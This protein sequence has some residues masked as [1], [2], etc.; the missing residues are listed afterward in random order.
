MPAMLSVTSWTPVAF[1]LYR[2][3]G[4]VGAVTAHLPATELYAGGGHAACCRRR[5]SELAVF[6]ITE[7]ATGY[8]HGECSSGGALHVHEQ[9]IVHDGRTQSDIR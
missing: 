7:L 2:Q 6:T 3:H 1:V 8:P 5:A 4:N 9:A